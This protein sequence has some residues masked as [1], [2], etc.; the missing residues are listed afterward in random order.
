MKIEKITIIDSEVVMAMTH[1][2]PQLEA[3]IIPPTS[4]ELVAMVSSDNFHLF[5][6]RV[7]KHIVGTL[8]LV[9]YRIPTGQ[10]SWIEDVIVD[11]QQR[12]KGIGIALVRY[13]I[14]FAQQQGIE[15]IDLTSSYDRIIANQLYQKIG[16]QK[17]ASN[18]Y[19]LYP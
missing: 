5:V 4:E 16:F 9:T 17:R 15:K 1:L 12:G 2:L 8:S 18:L 6:A 14:R 3:T 7:E 13:A 19:R 10:K 11:S